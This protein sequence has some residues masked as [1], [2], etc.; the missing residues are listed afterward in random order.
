MSLPGILAEIVARKREELHELRRR[1]SSLEAAVRDAPRC[2]P[3]LGALGNGGRVG[4]IAEC[5]RRSPGAGPIRPGLDPAR[6]SVAYERAGASCLSVLTDRDFFGG[7]PDDLRAARAATRLPVLRKDFTLDPL[8]VLE[9]RAMGA[10]AVLLIVRILPN[11][12]LR[13]LFDE[14]TG[15]GMDVLVETHDEAELE[16][17][18]ALGAALVGINNRDLSTFTTTLDTTLRLM[19]LVPDDVTLVSE[20]GIRGFEDALAL[21][22]A[23][24][25]AVLVGETLLRAEDSGREARS[26]AGADRVERRTGRAYRDQ[27]GRKASG[28][29]FKVCGVQRRA[30]A[31]LADRLGASHVG[32]I[33]SDGFGRSVDPQVSGAMLDGV[34]AKRVAVMVNEPVDQAVRRALAVGA[35]VVQLHGDEP[36]DDVAALAER[37]QWTVWKGVRAA[38]VGDVE[39]AA[40]LYGGIVDG[41]VV[42]GR[43]DGVMGGGGARLRVSPSSVRSAL[44]PE[45][46]FVLAGGLTPDN[47]QGAAAEF[48]PDVVDVSSGIERDPGRKDA[49]LMRA[50]ASLAVTLGRDGDP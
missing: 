40:R 20:S 15:L 23:G 11:G 25:D 36:A 8:H 16:R 49:S 12:L 6:L 48:R 45:T 22:R 31:L 42:E 21:G 7:S 43:K 27:D 26:L 46:L 1:S 41:F 3:F 34:R 35:E 10:D 4:L 2:R 13:R 44:P 17:A 18:L 9:A 37:G 19:E 50:F 47:L 39:W 24:V 29:A 30:D 32:V 28:T 38:S 33:V 14:A 5:K